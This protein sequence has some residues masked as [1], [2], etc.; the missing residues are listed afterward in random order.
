MQSVVQPVRA[1]D[2]LVHLQYS[3]KVSN[4]WNAG[5]AIDN[6]EILDARTG[7]SIGT[8]HAFAV[9]GIEVTGKIRPPEIVE[10]AD[11]QTYEASDYRDRLQRGGSGYM[12]MDLTFQSM[13][14]VPTCIIHRFTVHYSDGLE[15]N[16][17]WIAEDAGIPV[18]RLNAVVIS[19]PLK[20]SNW[21]DANG[22]GP[23]ISPHRY[24][25]IPGN[26]SLHAMEQFAVDFMQLNDEGRSV[27]N[28]DLKK[29]ESYN[30]YGQDVL[31]ATKGR[32]IEA[33][34]HFP[35]GMPTELGENPDDFDDY[36]G[37]R[38]V[39]AIGGGRYAY[40]A[41]LMPGT[42]RVKQGQFVA[43]GHV[44]GR[45]G[46]SGSSSAPHL[47]FEI[48][49]G[50]K[51]MQSTSLPFVFRRI[52]FLGAVNDTWASADE[53]VEGGKR[54]TINEARTGFRALQMPLSLDVIEFPDK[55]RNP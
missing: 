25:V 23:I 49:D 42:V 47:H 31:S 22:A 48:M 21:I 33:V 18:R 8:N 3:L 6:V 39:I 12:Y 1:T 24:G 50:P 32:V 15:L 46:N 20:G 44:L 5:V 11:Q 52:K 38:V 9:D 36:G 40:Y 37:N 35:D 14:Q 4:E 55:A 30:S 41:H 16:R 53:A 43:V 34:D 19:P 7:Q 45:V 28:N 29:N 54:V 27:N 2:G 13:K 17:T 10:L 51:V 26:G